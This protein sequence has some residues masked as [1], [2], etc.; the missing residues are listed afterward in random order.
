MEAL[1]WNT[2]FG[3]AQQFP[4]RSAIDFFLPFDAI[5]FWQMRTILVEVRVLDRGHGEPVGMAAP[6]GG[7]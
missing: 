1:R 7:D 5:H 6:T 4:V 3:C 2:P